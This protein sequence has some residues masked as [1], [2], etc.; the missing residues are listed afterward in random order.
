MEK[1][2]NLHPLFI[3]LWIN[4]A[5]LLHLKLEK[6]NVN[7][8]KES[9]TFATSSKSNE[10]ITPTRATTT[11]KEQLIN[12]YL[13]CFIIVNELIRHGYQFRSEIVLKQK[14]KQKLWV[15]I[16][17]ILEIR[18]KNFFFFLSFSLNI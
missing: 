7:K 3:N 4:L 1:L 18:E 16:I 5:D 8:E 15:K 10:I 6:E 14:Q 17:I 9:N 13:V 12:Q 11:T 2:I